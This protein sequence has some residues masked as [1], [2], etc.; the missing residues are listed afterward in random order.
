M[1]GSLPSRVL[2]LAAVVV[3]YNRLDKLRATVERLLGEAL[4]HIIVVDNGSSDGSRAWLTRQ[5]DPRLRL[6][7]ADENLGGAG[8]FEQ[9]MRLAMAEY[10]P[11]WLILMD[12][13]GRPAPGT[14]ADF[15]AA[16]HGDWDAYAAA[17]RYPSGEIC[18]MN[19]PTV[20]PFW[21]LRAFFRT[22]FRGGQEGFHIPDAAYAPGAGQRQIDVT[23]FVGFF[24]SRETVARV[25]F[26]DGRLFVYG[27]DVLYTL[28]ISAA[29]LRIAFA[30]EYRF[31]HDCSTFLAEVRVYRPLW[32][33]YYNFRNG[34]LVYRQ[35]AGI[36]FWPAL[37][38]EVP[39]WF[40][41]A[42][43]YGADAG[44]YRR[45][46]ARAVRDGLFHRLEDADIR[47]GGGDTDIRPGGGEIRPGGPS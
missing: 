41:A 40:L 23:S 44:A 3:T 7:Y 20:N 18:E 4:D 47:P 10:N 16:P 21:H 39:L 42:R 24:V 37:C 5:T 26:P 38:L 17:V 8:G 22:L 14:I 31:E 2:T 19:R 35:A 15:R 27:D 46:L 36:F 34:I 12:D 28:G 25:G 1:E 45:L 13:D 43:R 32:K 30:P 6:I 9:G 29:G 11:D 33:V